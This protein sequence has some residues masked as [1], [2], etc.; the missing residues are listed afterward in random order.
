MAGLDPDKAQDNTKPKPRD[1]DDDYHLKEALFMAK[2]WFRDPDNPKAMLPGPE[3]PLH[4]SLHPGRRILI[5][6]FQLWNSGLFF[7]CDIP[8]HVS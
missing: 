2:N 3:N 1:E 5:N 4:I 8:E 6:R 7:A